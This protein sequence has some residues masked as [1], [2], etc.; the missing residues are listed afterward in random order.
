M[1]GK[2][3]F[4]LSKPLDYITLTVISFMHLNVQSPV[5][6]LVWEGL[7][8]VR[9]DVIRS[10]FHVS[11]DLYHSQSPFFV[12]VHVCTS[13]FYIKMLTL[14]YRSS[15]SLPACCLDSHGLSSSETITLK[16]NFFFSQLLCHG[17]QPQQWKSN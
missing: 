5:V 6:G 13:W 15:S 12:C 10:G 7:T 1:T 14:G 11:K 17:V 8:D 3:Y 2:C 9:D 16:L 4:Y